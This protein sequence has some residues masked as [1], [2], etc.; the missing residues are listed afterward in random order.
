MIVNGKYYVLQE[1]ENQK[2]TYSELN[3]N[4]SCVKEQLELRDKL[5]KVSWYNFLFFDL[6]IYKVLCEQ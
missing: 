2:R 6:F 3:T 4:F 5:V 1:L